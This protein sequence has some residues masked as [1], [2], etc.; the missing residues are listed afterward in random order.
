MSTVVIAGGSGFL[1]GAL[2][3]RLA[4]EHTVIV[5]T[6]SKPRKETKEGDRV[7]TVQW[8]PDGTLGDWAAA[9]EGTDAIV[10]L[11]GAGIADRR[12]TEARKRELIDSRVQST[13]SLV[14]AVLSATNPP[15]TF[16]Q[17]SG[18]GFYG[19]YDDGP[20]FDEASPPG[21]DF[22]A[23]MAIQWEASVKP[24]ET[25]GTRLV[26]VRT[27][28]V[29]AKHGGALKKMM[30]PF[31]FFAGGPIGSGR[32]Y[33]SW[34]HLEDWTGMIAWAIRMRL[35]T[36]TINATAPNPV[37]NWEFCRALGRAMR[38]PSWAP[39]PGFVLK[40]MFGE[41]AE[42]ALL[43]GQRAVPSHANEL[44]FAFRYQ[45]IRPAFAAIFGHKP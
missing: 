9:I 15:K 19:A 39:V 29:L 11:A 8:T 34:I 6:R 28:I 21:H 26:T 4:R 17:Q 10:N 45:E 25:I 5:L 30:L 37:Q 16:I 43:K 13:A 38:R 36:G 32:Q 20:L 1:G 44:K 41:M 18:V 33:M 3:P 31:R 7:R 27:G 24:V 42:V 35:V 23:E 22:L 12:W 40:M 2:V 14:Q